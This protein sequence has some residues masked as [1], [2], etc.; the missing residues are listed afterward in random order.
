MSQ[1]Q[2]E[3]G[4]EIWI[5]WVGERGKFGIKVSTYFGEEFIFYADDVNVSHVFPAKPR[6]GLTR[7][8]ISTQGVIMKV[9]QPFVI[10]G[11]M[12]GNTMDI[13][14]HHEK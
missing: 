2:F 13:R 8:N 9:T 7:M 5:R 6:P 11:L 12:M 1:Q 3:M 10:S 14:L 4:K